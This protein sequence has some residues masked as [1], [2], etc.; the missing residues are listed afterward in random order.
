MKKWMIFLLLI[1]IVGCGA[2]ARQYVGPVKDDVAMTAPARQLALS[3][4]MVNYHV[5]AASLAVSGNMVMADIDNPTIKIDALNAK[6]YKQRMENRQK[7]YDE[8]IRKRGFANIKGEYD[9][10][11]NSSCQNIMIYGGPTTIEQSEYKIV[12][13]NGP[14]KHRGVIVENY[15]GIEHFALSPEVYLVGEI[16]GNNIQIEHL[17]SGCVMEL[18]KK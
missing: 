12:F 14:V 4:Y 6:E 15:L 8:A 13:K 11:I 5:T 16:K 10:K 17:P 9:T 2:A 1:W 7:V 3:Y 18:T